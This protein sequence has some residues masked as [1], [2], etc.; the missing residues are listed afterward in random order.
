MPFYFTC[1]AYTRGRQSICANTTW[2]PRHIHRTCHVAVSDTV[3]VTTRD[4]EEYEWV[5]L[6]F[7]NE[8]KYQTIFFSKRLEIIQNWQ[9]RFAS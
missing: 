5:Q 1:I 9:K 3:R 6:T 7:F 4:F 8:N 2:M